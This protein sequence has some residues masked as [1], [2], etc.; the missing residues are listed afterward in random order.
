MDGNETYLKLVKAMLDDRPKQI[1]HAIYSD[2]Q[3]RYMYIHVNI[4]LLNSI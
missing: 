1:A 4:C 2:S 3:I